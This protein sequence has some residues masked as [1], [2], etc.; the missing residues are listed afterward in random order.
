MDEWVRNVSPHLADDEYE[1]LHSEVMPMDPD[2]L[3]RV[4]VTHESSNPWPSPNGALS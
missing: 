4:G 1:N 3:R 2:Q